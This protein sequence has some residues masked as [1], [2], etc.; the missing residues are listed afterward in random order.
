MRDKSY[1]ELSIVVPL[2][3]EEENVDLL[4]R[5]IVDAVADIGKSVEFVFVDD[6]SRDSTFKVAE[7]VA[8]TD[9]CSL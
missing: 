8:A 9:P 3:N 1:P 5:A 6:G 7:E 2:Y 4:Y